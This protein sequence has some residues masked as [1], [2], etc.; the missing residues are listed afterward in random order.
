MDQIQLP[1]EEYT[2]PNPVTVSESVPLAELVALMKENGVRHLPVVRGNSVVG[3]ISER[4]LRIAMGLGERQ[5]ISIFARDV[6]IENPITVSSADSL[7]KVALLMSQEKI[8]SV[9]VNDDNDQFLGIFTV[10]DALNA[11]IEIVRSTEH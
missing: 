2:T 5:K 11:L 10:T 1:V 9:I 6:M 4:D 3:I 8:G 7:D